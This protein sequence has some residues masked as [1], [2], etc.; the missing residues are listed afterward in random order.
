MAEAA[1]RRY[2][3]EEYIALDEVSEEKHEY[4]DGRILLMAEDRNPELEESSSRHSAMQ[5]R[6]AMLLGQQLPGGARLL[7]TAGPRV[8]VLA[9]GLVTYPDITVICG[10]LLRDPGS[11]NAATNP[12]VLVEVLSPRTERYDLGEKIVHYQQI[13][14]LKE[15]VLVF[16][17][18]QKVEVFHS[19][20]DGSWRHK[21]TGPGGGARI[22][23]IGATLTVDELYEGMPDDDGIDGR[24][25][26]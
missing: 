24:G 6:I 1:L 11:T 15:Y 18:L 22:D 20:G 12:T 23:A 16:M 19:N 17:R 13:P 14:S 10:P 3:F 4:L 7:Y 26:A 8:R 5:S 21:S 2:T 25:P 9:T